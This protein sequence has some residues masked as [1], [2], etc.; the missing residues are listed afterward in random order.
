M[1]NKIP[2]YLITIADNQYNPVKIIRAKLSFLDKTII[3]SSKAVKSIYLQAENA[4]RNNFIQEINP[5]VKFISLIYMSAV[6]SVVNNPV[7][8]IFI[9][10]FIFLSYIIARLNIF[11]IYKKIFL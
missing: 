11:E 10:A 5:K 7:A 8:Q 1:E 3:N 4:A 2:P 6:V 9:S